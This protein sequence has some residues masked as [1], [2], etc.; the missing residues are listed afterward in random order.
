MRSAGE[1]P[2]AAEL[3]AGIRL[4]RLCQVL[5]LAASLT[6]GRTIGQGGVCCPA[7]GCRVLKAVS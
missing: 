4:L 6:I 1:P 7:V 2:L 5:R 3:L